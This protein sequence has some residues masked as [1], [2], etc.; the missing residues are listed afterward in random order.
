MIKLKIKHAIGFWHPFCPKIGVI[1]PEMMHVPWKIQ[2]DDW[3]D[4]TLDQKLKIWSPP[5]PNLHLIGSICMQL[6]EI[7]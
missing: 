1:M 6:E 2:E 5:M 7:D 4:A 3:Q